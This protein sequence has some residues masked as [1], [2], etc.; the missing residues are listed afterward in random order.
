MKKKLA[1]IA[2]SFSTIF[3]SF[4]QTD[5]HFSMFAESPVYLNPATAGFTPGDLQLFTNYRLQWSTVSDNPYRTISASADWRFFDQGGSFMGAG[6]NFYNDLAGV[7]KYQT[8][9]I[10]LPLNYAIQLDK[11]NHLSIGLQPAF[12]QRTIKNDELNWFNQWNGVAYDQSINN[13][14]LILS[15][16]FSVSRFDV[17]AGV[18]WSGWINRNSRLKLGISGQHLTKQRIN[19]TSEDS[20]LYRKLNIHGQG[21]FRNE[22]TGVTILPA[23]AA[24]LQGPNKELLIGSNFRFLLKGGSRST[25]Y[26]EEITFSVGSY[27]RVGD[28][29]II[30]TILDLS[31]FSFGASYDLNVSKL[32]AASKGVGAMEFFLKYRIQFGTRNLR[33]NRVH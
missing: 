5:Q 22:T 1:L 32:T 4:G 25:S 27:F 11:N 24:F 12:Y 29:L 30:N 9:V 10:S 14:E 7:A 3:C 16:N 19:F 21:E 2:L 28:A 15:Q 17:A 20:K 26:F 33:N 8:N 18:F 6:L 31:G 13:N 23:F